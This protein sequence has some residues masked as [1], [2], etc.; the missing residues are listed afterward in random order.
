[1]L[2]VLTPPPSPPQ[3]S[4]TMAN[5]AEREKIKMN[6]RRLFATLAEEVEI[7]SPWKRTPSGG[8]S[9]LE[10]N[11]ET[12]I[13]DGRLAPAGCAQRLRSR[14]TGQS[15]PARPA[16]PPPSHTWRGPCCI[17]PDID[18]FARP[19]RRQTLTCRTHPIGQEAMRCDTDR[20]RS[21]DDPDSGPHDQHAA[22]ASVAA[23]HGRNQAA[24][25]ERPGRPT[26]M[27]V[28]MPWV[29]R[30][31]VRRIQGGIASPN[32]TATTC[33]SWKSLAAPSPNMLEPW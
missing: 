8:N 3:E 14:V 5:D 13:S 7:L 25:P 17:L 24:R 29:L 28:I 15:G 10:R 9:G 26:R 4:G 6:C 11:R 20:S 32:N 31:P 23:S 2:P 1:M 22:V 12:G 19:T 27:T 21:A 18:V 30:G 16:T 33:P